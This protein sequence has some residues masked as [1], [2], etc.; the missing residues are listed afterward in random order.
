ME[1]TKKTSITVS[2]DLWRTAKI[3]AAQENIP[4]GVLVSTA[5]AEY[6][7]KPRQKRGEK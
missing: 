2:R 4:V 6:C 7:K 5:I 3:R 1:E